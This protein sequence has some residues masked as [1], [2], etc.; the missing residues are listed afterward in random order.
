VIP[1]GALRE[2]GFRLFFVGQTTSLLGDGM[3]GVA[4]SFAVLDLTGSVSDLG[5]VLAARALPFVGFLL[6]GGVFADRIS[7]RTV[8][9]SADLVRLGSQ[10]LTAGLLITGHAQ[11]WELAALQAVGGLASAFFYPAVTGLTPVL[12]AP[13]QLQQ[14]NVLRGISQGA[15]G[16]AGPAIAGVL[17][18]TAGAGWAL[19]VDAVTFGLS[20]TALAMLRVPPYARLEVQSF[21]RDLRDGWSAFRSLTWLWT[22]VCC[23]GLVVMLNAPFS[24]LGPAI[25]KSSLGGAGAWAGIVAG[26]SAGSFLGGLL[27]LRLRP[28]YPFRAAFVGFLPFGSPMVLLAVHAPAATIAVLAFVAGAG[29]TTGNALWETTVQEQVPPD[30]LARVASYDWFGSLAGQPVGMALVGPVSA[31]IGARPTLVG[32]SLLI[33]A[34]NLTVLSL[35]SV[36]AVESAAARSGEPAVRA[37]D[38]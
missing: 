38:A 23:A 21:L 4:L 34:A 11:I 9:L 35:R 2:R 25:A 18:A 6:V 12:V 5:Y 20:A 31:A 24:V 1:L 29:L 13:E 10:G 27:A 14:A 8:M 32:A 17:V 7:R 30:M 22:G 28:R 16:I 36:R 37:L 19:A 33:L 3:V 26:Q 15:G